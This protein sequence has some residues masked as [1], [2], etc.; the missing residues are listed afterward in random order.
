MNAEKL[1]EIKERA[2]KATSGPWLALYEGTNAEI[3][4]TKTAED[5]CEITAKDEYHAEDAEFISNAR[6]DVPALV[7]EVERLQAQLEKCEGL[8]SWAHDVL[9]DV[10]CYETDVYEEIT[11]YFDGDDSD[12]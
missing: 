1:N 4:S 5:I 12:D 10:H 6:E 3:Y 9:D 2:E 11:Q 8:L 7:A